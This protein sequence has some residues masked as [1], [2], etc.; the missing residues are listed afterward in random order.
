[1]RRSSILFYFLGTVGLAGLLGGCG[2]G[3]GGASPG[4][5]VASG[6][7]AASGIITGFGSVFVNGKKFE[8]SKASFIVDDQ[9][10][11]QNDLK[12]G[13]MVEVRGSFSG[14]DRSASS[15]RQKDAVEGLVQLV[16][17]DGLSLVVLGQLVQLD[18]S[19]RIDD[20]IDSTLPKEN[21]DIR[22]LIAGTDSVEVNGF[23][24]PDGV[25]Q[26]T[27]IE[28][29]AVGTVTP[30]VRGFVNNH[31][32]GAK[33]F[34]IGNLTVDYKTANIGD[35]PNPAG[36]SWNGLLIEAKGTN[37]TPGPNVQTQG[38][39]VATM[40]EPENPAVG[41][42]D[43]F[44]IEGFVK[45]VLGPGDF[46]I[47]NTHVQTTSATEFRGGMI[48]EIVLG[49][50]LSAEGRL[51]NGVLT[52]KE[53]KFEDSVKL[54]GNIAEINL[55]SKTFTITGLPG[56][57]VSVNSQTEL[58]ANGGNTIIDLN[59]LLVGDHVRVRSRVGGSTSVLAT[60]VEQRSAGD[61]VD[62]Q[63][64]VQAPSNPT[65][66]ILG[67]AVDTSG[68]A[69]ANF[70]GLDDG[71]IGRAAFFNAVKVG[72]LVKMN[73]RLSGSVVTWREAELEDGR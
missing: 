38:T 56:V 11:S 73:G 2:S 72:T 63:G 53:V 43:E 64:P 10:G 57:T 22:K 47:G 18:S 27:F 48:D 31:N 39:L 30:E 16:A 32:D 3:G 68:I 55:V 58:K 52:A 29:K 62:L 40:V 37:F 14:N 21:R 6:S 65:L 60:R 5:G 67:V 28:K 49:T 54:E 44:E 4:T 51:T 36:N 24:K 17:A 15:V 33:T 12:L 13:M 45:Q 9:P 59:D 41:D 61:D 69:D 23:I 25:I 7:A 19:T 46:F 20:S 34:Q 35:M 70:K 8:T 1:M 66:T 50:K 26:A 42:S 71:T